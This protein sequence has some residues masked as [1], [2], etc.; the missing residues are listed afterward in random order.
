MPLSGLEWA[1][2]FPGSKSTDDLVEPFRSCAKKFIAAL[3]AAHA[4]VALDD[5]FRPPE[6]AYLMHYSF[7]IARKNRDPGAVPPKAGVDIQWVHKHARG[8]PDLVA[9][10]AA[11]EQMVYGYG[12]V[13]EPV[14][15]SRHTQ[16]LAI[17]MTIAWQGNL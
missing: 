8:Q 15:E 16:R 5:T 1:S 4:S 13:F 6:R 17:D 14:L 12:I 2:K 11:A 10:K 9:S 7:E 3:H